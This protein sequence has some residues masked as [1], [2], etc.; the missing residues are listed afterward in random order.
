[1]PTLNLFFALTLAFQIVS[2]PQAIA[3]LDKAS[4][5][6][7]EKTQKLLRDPSQRNAAMNQSPDARSN[8][9]ELQKL[10]GGKGTGGVYDLSA[11]IFAKIVSESNGDVVVMQ[12]KLEQAQT[13]PEA[14]L[15]SLTP[16]QQARIKSMA[17][18]ASE[19]RNPSNKP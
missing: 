4:Q 8:D 11:D 17:N 13:N 15:K 14:F 12:Q 7:L 3:E 5:E 2:L 16:E 9:A 19:K 18:Q 1:M 6:A 10:M